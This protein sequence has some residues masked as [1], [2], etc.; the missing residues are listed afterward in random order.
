MTPL[1]IGCGN[2]HRGDDA[3]GPLVARRLREL[4]VRA[5][6]ESGEGL[7]LIE[8][9]SGAAHVI[10][11]DAVITGAPAGTVTVFDPRLGPVPHTPR[12]STHSFGVAEAIE[13]ARTLDRLPPALEIY[14]IEANQFEAGSEPSPE[15]LAAVER[16][17]QEVLQCTNPASSKTC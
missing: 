15:V 12:A 1:I 6:E 8:S 16:V 11:I 17:A 5:R 14:G 2:E 13:L 9:W 4:G 7:A 3:A 10:L